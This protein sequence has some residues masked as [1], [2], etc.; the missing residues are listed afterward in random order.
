MKKIFICVLV[1]LFFLAPVSGS[2]AEDISG[3]TADLGSTS[4]KPPVA[5]E[6]EIAMVYWQLARKT[7]N[8]DAMAKST[9]EYKK[10]G[11]FER[12]QVLSA[13]K[14]NMMNIHANINFSQPTVVKMLVHLSPYSEKNKGFVIGCQEV[15]SPGPSAPLRT[16]T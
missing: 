11:E 16:R 14:A 4:A 5:S 7:P 8:F 1:S 15:T 2:R 13:Q 10:A 6:A 9:E 3:L 12:D